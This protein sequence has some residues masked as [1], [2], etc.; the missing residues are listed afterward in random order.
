MRLPFPSRTYVRTHTRTQPTVGIDNNYASEYNITLEVM[1]KIKTTLL[2]KPHNRNNMLWAACCVA[3]FGFLRCSEFT[4]PAQAE[5]DPDTHLSLTDIIID[6]KEAPS[7]VYITIK[8]SKTDPFRQGVQICLG[9]TDKSICPVNALLPYLAV[10]GA[11]SGPLFIL[12]EGAYLTR[13][14]YCLTAVWDT[15]EGRY[16]PQELFDAQLSY[17]GSHHS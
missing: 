4:V 3:F 2:N 5:Y 12:A 14:K 17:W 7:R 13:Q 15:T 1:T 16:G 6:N 9:K 11:C 10:R 8:Q